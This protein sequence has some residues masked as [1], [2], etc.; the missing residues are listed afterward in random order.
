MGNVQVGNQAGYVFQN[1]VF[2]MLKEYVAWKGWSIHF[3]RTT[4]KAEV[5]FV[6]N[7]KNQILP[8]EVKFGKMTKPIL[9]RSF[10]SFVKKYE[11]KEAWLISPFYNNEIQLENTRV[12]FLPFYKIYE[13]E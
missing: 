13:E 4:D 6:I 5:D 1:L 2:I 9:S 3:W 7:K 11:P 10:R 12:R 8:V